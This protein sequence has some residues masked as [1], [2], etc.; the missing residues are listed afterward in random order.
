M[1][2]RK[3]Y[4]VLILSVFS[5]WNSAFSQV[6]YGT[7]VGTVTDSDGKAVAGATVTATNT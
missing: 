4:F 6:L 3:I 1:K 2:L 5:I 7:L